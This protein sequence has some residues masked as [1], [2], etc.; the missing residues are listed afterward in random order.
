MISFAFLIA[1]TAFDASNFNRQYSNLLLMLPLLMLPLLM[2]P[3]LMLPLLMLPLL[4]LPLLM[5]R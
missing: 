5:L 2:L 3:L 1:F 4:M